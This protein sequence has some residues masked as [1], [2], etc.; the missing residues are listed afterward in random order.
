MKGKT[1]IILILCG[2]LLA[3]TGWFA[4]QEYEKRSSENPMVQAD[5]LMRNITWGTPLEEFTPYRKNDEVELVFI[6]EPTEGVNTASIDVSELKN[7]FDGITIKVDDRS[8]QESELNNLSASGAFK[9]TVRGK[10]KENTMSGTEP[11]D[12]LKIRF[13]KRLAQDSE[14]KP[15]VDL[16]KTGSGNID[17]T[18]TPSKPSGLSLP[19]GTLSSN[20]DNLIPLIGK[21]LD[22]ID[23]VVIGEKSFK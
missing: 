22:G 15:N 11:K 10:G 12:F 3:T 7:R 21:G 8:V 14:E 9:V 17:P 5:F 6:V 19:T 20:I 16:Q 18:N 13:S 2:A 4:W 23:R 1:P